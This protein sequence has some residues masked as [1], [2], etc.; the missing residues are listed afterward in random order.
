M[1]EVMTLLDTS[2]DS[3][4]VEDLL[5]RI[6]TLV[7]L[8]NGRVSW[9]H[10]ERNGFRLTAGVSLPE[11]ALPEGR[12]DLEG[13]EM[14]SPAHYLKHKVNVAPMYMPDEQ[15]AWIYRLI[16]IRT[17]SAPSEDVLG[18]ITLPGTD[19]VALFGFDVRNA[20]R[21]PVYEDKDLGDAEVWV[22]VGP[23]GK[24]VTYASHVIALR[25][26]TVLPDPE[27]G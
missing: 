14:R 22:A 5:Q 27:V 8:P 11:S 25:L 16:E 9:L 19:L 3:G 15:R 20:L 12:Y 13:D 24:P 10:Y 1:S 6:R 26:D 4:R 18:L 21:I 2:V 17:A 7:S 23:T